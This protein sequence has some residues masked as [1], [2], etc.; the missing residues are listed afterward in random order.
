[1]PSNLCSKVTQHI[2]CQSVF[3]VKMLDTHLPGRT[4]QH[5]LCCI[6]SCLPPVCSKAAEQRQPATQQMLEKALDGMLCRCTGYRPILDSCK[7]GVSMAP[8]PCLLA[9]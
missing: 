2:S 3:G 6:V 1:M 7:V 4:S 5:T 8:G 9:A